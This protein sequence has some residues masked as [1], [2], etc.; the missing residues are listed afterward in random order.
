LVKRKKSA[1]EAICSSETKEEQMASGQADRGIWGMLM[2]GGKRRP[3]P[4]GM[5]VKGRCLFSMHLPPR[6][7]LRLNPSPCPPQILRIC[8]KGCCAR[9]GARRAEPAPRYGGGVDRH[10]NENTICT[11]FSLLDAKRVH[12]YVRT[13]VL[14]C[15]GGRPRVAAPI[16]SKEPGTPA[17]ALLKG[18]TCHLSH[19]SYHGAAGL[20]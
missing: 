1:G 11:G 6:W 13:F 15:Q 20:A 9:E 2:C 5:A 10:G 17:P 7:H 3:G 8:P 14:V 4:A 16:E 18:R 12:S 19:V